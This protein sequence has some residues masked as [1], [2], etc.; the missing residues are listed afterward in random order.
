MV[1][2]VLVGLVYVICEVYLDD[3]I[4]HGK[5]S[6]ELVARLRTVFERF[7]K[8]NVTLHPDKCHIGLRRINYVGHVIDK[9]G[10]TMA[11]ERIENLLQ[12]DEPTTHRF[13]KQFLGIAN[14]FRDHIPNYAKITRPLHQ[15]LGGYTKQQKN[16]PIRW[17]DQTRQSF[18]ETKQAINN[19]KKLYFLKDEGLVTVRTDAS[20]YAIGAYLCQ[21][22]EGKER[23][24]QFVSKSLIKEQVRW[25]T[26]EKECYAI[27]FCLME[28]EMYLRGRRF[29]LQTDHANLTYINLSGSAKVIR[30]KLA[31]QEFDFD[32]QHIKGTDNVVA[33][34]LSRLRPKETIHKEVI[35]AASPYAEAISDKLLHH[36][37]KVHS[38]LNGHWGV[39]KT[40]ILL[41]QRLAYQAHM[42]QSAKSKKAR[43]GKQKA[44]PKRGQAAVVEAIEAT[45]NQLRTTIKK[46]IHQCTSCQRM[47]HLKLQIHARPYTTATYRPMHTLNIDSMGPFPV[48]SHGYC[49]IIVII[50][51]FTR[52]VEMYPTTGATA[53]DAA[54]PLLNHF[55]R[56]GCPS[57]IR[58][59][60]GSEFV[61][62]MIEQFLKLVGTEHE[63][64]LAYSS[65]ENAI[66]ERANKEVLRHIKAMIFTDNRKDEWANYL[67][68]VQRIMNST[69]H[70]SLG[71]SPAEA[72]FGNNIKLEEGIFLPMEA[73]K[74]ELPPEK[75]DEW[76]G[77]M[78]IHQAEMLNIA[79]KT[80]LTK[81]I[82][83][84]ERA[85]GIRPT[86]FAENSYV[87]VKTS[88]K[89]TGKP[90]DK[91]TS[92]WK[93]PMRVVNNKVPNKYTVQN[94]ITLKMED[95]HVTS[96]KQ[97]IYDPLVTDPTEVANRDENVTTVERIVSHRGDIKDKSRVTF[98]VRWLGQDESEDTYESFENLKRNEHLHRYLMAN[99]GKSI[100]PRAFREVVPRRL[101]AQKARVVK[102]ARPQA[103]NALPQRALSGRLRQRNRRYG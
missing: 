24:I 43:K 96:L 49:H 62:T 85:K 31:I 82:T 6:K 74:N 86:L 38:T 84:L 93:G 12:F 65:E 100:I 39:E 77:K 15:I 75:M 11:D 91:F 64:S 19:C 41:K 29:L 33:D 69:T 103:K 36:L 61:N 99:G 87:L 51:C 97:F 16:T 102:P 34:A 25:S 66:V 18:I 58:S 92:H 13:L 73:I 3:S 42:K 46:F 67:P 27:Y 78:L 7:R 30:W 26:P 88:S 40:L 32:I 20:D 81:D 53:K 1:T 68:L 57:V 8:Y 95:Y 21:M 98:R 54:L 90:P 79:R 4:V 22:Q 59:D 44:T 48:Q 2:I 47:S 83:H 50:D 55:G 28:L 52:F 70:S 63:L 9:D 10:I 80:Q 23:P 14:Y 56:Y 76:V 89:Y 45:D 94:L 101:K 37:K 60:N 71:I 35:Y 72:L 17:T 5:T